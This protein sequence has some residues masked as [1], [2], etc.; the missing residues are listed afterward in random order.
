MKTKPDHSKL[1][2]MIL[3]IA[4][5]SAGDPL[6]GK[7]KIN[8][9]LFYSDFLAHL[10]CG[11]S[12][13]GE[14]YQALQ[15]GPAPRGMLPT[16]K[17]METAKDI[18]IQCDADPFAP[19]KIFA[20]RKPDLSLFTAEQIDIVNRCIDDFRGQ[21]GTELSNKSHRFVGWALAQPRET[22]PYSMAL[23]GSREPSLAERRY[24]ESLGSRAKECVAGNATTTV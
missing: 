3:Y 1:R 11:Q 22:I 18:A 15:Q 4:D 5:R 2:E 20:L 21:N 17:T 16:L 13:T 24:G 19:H 8:K 7:V 10:N 9:L 6:F 23:I 14:E 12:I